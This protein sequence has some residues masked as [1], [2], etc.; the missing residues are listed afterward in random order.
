MAR[1]RGTDA[2][3]TTTRTRILAAAM[4]QMGCFRR[5]DILEAQLDTDRRL[6]RVLAKLEDDDQSA[7][8]AQRVNACRLYV[9]L[10]WEQAA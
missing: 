6:R 9:P 2:S 7:L 1:P 10:E 4:R 8:I 5:R 3:G